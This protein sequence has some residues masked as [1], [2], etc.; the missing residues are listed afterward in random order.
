MYYNFLA[1]GILIALISC[2][3][4]VS[5]QRERCLGAQNYCSG[6]GDMGA[7]CKDGYCVCTGRDYDYNTCLRKLL[8]FV[9][10]TKELQKASS[11]STKIVQKGKSDISQ[12]KLLVE[13][14]DTHAELKT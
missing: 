12:L 3:T 13:G 1:F 9:F 4:D 5:C 8:S 10:L 7:V 2:L 11:D 14:M 6:W